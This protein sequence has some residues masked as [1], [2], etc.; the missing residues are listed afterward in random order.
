MFSCLQPESPLSAIADFYGRKTSFYIGIVTVM[1]FTFLQ[2]PVSYSYDLFA[3]FKVNLE[4]NTGCWT[5]LKDELKPHFRFSPPL[6]C[7]L[8][9]SHPWIS[10]ARSVTSRTGHTRFSFPKKE[11]KVLTCVS[12]FVKWK[13]FRGYVICFACLTWSLGQIAFPLVGEN[14]FAFLSTF[15]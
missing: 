12:T 2:I 5:K 9:S 10:S 3:L 8:S 11:L 7:C 13:N 4:K 1:L 15:T 6:A 14:H